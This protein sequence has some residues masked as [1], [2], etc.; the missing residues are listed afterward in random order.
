MGL[1]DDFMRIADKGMKAVE[2]GALEKALTNGLD[3]VEGGLDKAIK[4]AEAAA[5]VPEKVLKVAEDKQDQVAKIAQNV[6][7]QA[8]KTINILQQ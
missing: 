3:K 4:S 1:F 7:Q 6:S 2:N 5:A 8:G